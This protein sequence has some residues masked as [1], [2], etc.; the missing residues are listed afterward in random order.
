M[1][2]H[3]VDYLVY[4]MVDYLVYLMVDYLVYLMVEKRAV[5]MELLL[6]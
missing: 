1:D 5:T 4:L 2:V 6:D 3:L